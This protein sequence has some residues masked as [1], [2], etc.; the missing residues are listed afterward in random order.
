MTRP[1]AVAASAAAIADAYRTLLGLDG[2]SVEEAAQAA[3]TPTGPTLP[4]LTDRIRARR[5]HELAA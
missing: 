4:E 5:A 2:S 3:W 1:E